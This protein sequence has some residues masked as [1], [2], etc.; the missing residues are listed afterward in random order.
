MATKNNCTDCKL[1]QYRKSIVQGSGDLNPDFLFFGEAPGKDED[2]DG[3]PFI[4]SSGKLLRTMIE[5]ASKD[6]HIK[7]FFINAVLCRPTDDYYGE[8]RAPT[9]TEV[10][11]C[12]PKV[13][14][15]IQRVN[16]RN[17]I[18]V[19]EVSYNFYHLLFPS[20]YRIQHPAYI[21]RRGGFCSPEYITN[22]YKLNRIFRGFE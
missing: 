17:I 11:Y 1:C 12:Q 6:L 18:Y 22:Q 3:I 7:V 10:Y 8:N 21:L 20:K 5:T 16:P 19:G 9:S 14:K 13:K 4:G 15:I 2:E